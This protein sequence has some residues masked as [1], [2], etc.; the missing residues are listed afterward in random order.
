MTWQ[1]YKEEWVGFNTCRFCAGSSIH[2]CSL[3]DC[4]PALKEAGQYFE[5]VIAKEEIRAMD[6]SA[7]KAAFAN[8]KAVGARY[9]GVRV[10]A[11]GSS[12]PEIVINPKGNFDAK[13]D[14]YMNAYDD[15]LIL[16]SAKG[17]E[18]IRITGIAQGNAFEDIEVQ[19]SDA[20]FG[21]KQKISG[22]IDKV[23][24]K[25]I[26]ETPPQSEGERLRC[27][28]MK[29]AVKGMFLNTGRS[30]AEERFISGNIGKYE[31]LFDICMNGDDLAFKK[32]L[33]ELQ[34]LQNEHI[35]GEEKG[36]QGEGTGE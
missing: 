4:K 27:E 7:L 16:I 31:E 6:K 12:Q 3:T 32:G 23:Y 29:E 15:D 19:L 25:M 26:A 5:T 33:I 8:A 2:T 11:E 14:Y 13:F 1:Q 20:G 17:K 10:E 21:W 34:R 18:C 30:A 24:N 36:R 9:I 35:L 22:A 28:G